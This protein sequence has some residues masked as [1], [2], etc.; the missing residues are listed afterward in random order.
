GI[1]DLRQDEPL[2]LGAQDPLEFEFSYHLTLANAE[3]NTAIIPNPDAYPIVGATQDIFVRLQDLSGNCFEVTMFT[4]TFAEVTS[5]PVTPN[6]YF[7][8]DQDENGE[9]IV[10]LQSLFTTMIL[11][12]QNPLDF[13]VTYHLNQADS[14]NG[15]NALPNPYTV[16]TSPLTIFVRV[17]NEDQPSCFDTTQN[18]EIVF[19]TPPPFNPTPSP[20]I[21]C[22]DDND[23]F[24]AFDLTLAD[25]D[26]TL[27]DPT[28]TV[29]YHTTFAN[30]QNDLFPIIGLYTNDN[31]Y[32]DEVWARVNSTQSS[33]FSVVRLE[34]FVR[35]I[36]EVFTPEPL[37]LCD[38]NNPG[39]GFEVFN[40]TLVEGEVLG[41]LDPTHYDIYYFVDES[42]AIAAGDSALDAPPGDYSQAI[43][44][45]GA[46]QNQ[47]AFNQT[48]YI[49]V[50]GNDLSV[51]PTTNPASNGE[52]CYAIIEL[53]LIVDPLP[54]VFQPANYEL[55][56]DEINGSTPTDQLSTFDLTTREDEITGGDASLTVVWFETA[57]DEAANIN[58]IPD[59]TAYQNR[60][61]APATQ[62]TPQTIFAR[63][64]DARDCKRIVTLTLVVLPNPIAN[65]PDP[66]EECDNG[67]DLD[68]GLASFDLT[69]RSAQI[70]GGQ[71]NVTVLYYVTEQEALAGVAGTEIPDPT[72][73]TNVVPFFDSVWARAIRAANPPSVNLACSDVVELFLIVL[74][75]PDT[76]TASFG[77]LFSCDG[78]GNGNAIFD[79]T[80]NN[81]HVIG[82]QDPSDFIGP[83]YYTTLGA[84]QAGIPGTEIPNS[85]FFP[86][87][88][89]P[90]TIWVRLENISTG[91]VRISS[92][93]LITGTFPTIF[94]PLDKEECDDLESGSDTDGINIFN[95]TDYNAEITG[96][97]ATYEVFYY[98]TAQD[99]IDGNAIQTPEA[100]ANT[101]SPGE[102]T[103]FVS[104][105]NGEGCEARTTLTLR[106]LAL[107]APLTDAQYIVCD[108]NNDGTGEFIFSTMDVVIANG[109]TDVVIT[110]HETQADALEGVSALNP[111]LVYE[112][113]TNPQIIWVRVTREVLPP[114]TS[115]VCF[116]VVEL[117]LLVETS[118]VLPLDIPP[119]V[120]CAE[121]TTAVFNF[122]EE[123]FL[124]FLYG[125]QAPP[126]YLLSFHTT[127]ADA[128]AGEEAIP[129]PESY[130]N[131][132]NPQTIYVRLTNTENGC[133][134]V[135]DF[136][137]EVSQGP[138]VTAPTSLDA[139]HDPTLALGF[140]RFVLS[141]KDDEITGGVAGV[142]VRYYETQ[143]DAQND[144]NAVS[145]LDYINSEAFL[146]TL[147]V[148]VIDGNTGC[149]S[150][151]TLLLRV[152]PNPVVTIPDPL[153]LCDDN[154]PG[155]GIEEFNLRDAEAQMGLSAS[156]EVFYYVLESDAIEGDT[157][158]AIPEVAGE[159]PYINETPFFQTVYARVVNT[160]QVLRCFTIVPIDLIVHP[161][162][163]ASAEIEDLVECE[164]NNDGFA[165]FNL[166]LRI[167]QILNGQDPDIHQVTF[168]RTA[169]EAQARLNQIVNTS[170]FPNTTNPQEIYTGILN[171]ETGCYS[172][173][174]QFFLIRV[175]EDATATAPAAPLV[176]CED[177]Q[178]S[179]VGTFDLS[180][181][182]A[183]ILNGQDP[184]IYVLTYHESL[185]QAEAGE[186]PIPSTTTA[187]E[188][189]TATI[190]ARVTFP[191]DDPDQPFPA[192]CY[193]VVE[194]QLEVNPLPVPV[195]FQ[196]S[197]RLCVDEFGNVIGQEFGAD[198]PPLIDTGLSRP[199]YE[200]IWEID[201]QEQ[202]G[203]IEGS[204]V[205]LAG[206]VYTVTIIDV[207]TGCE[208]S[209][210]TTVTLSSPPLTFSAI[211]T[212]G[213]FAQTHQIEAIATGLGSYV[214]S[215]DGGPFQQSGI[216]VNVS[217]GSHIVTITDENGCGSVEVEV[218]IIDYPLF[219]TPN[220]DGYNDRWNII[221]IASNPTA[222]IYIFDR[223]GKLL[224]QISPT[225]EGWDGT[226][227]GNP[228]PSS[229]YWFRVEYIED[230]IQKQFR[231][232]FTL[233]R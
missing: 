164:V 60:T 160:N 140:S 181:L 212:N 114:S 96:G 169:A 94:D 103:L 64:T 17:E 161:L 221:G 71:T 171:T 38:Y 128:V 53:E 155:D 73:Y 226:Y 120:K 147:F 52:S 191:V 142:E 88:S 178:G 134:A 233:K 180:S 5:G 207:V 182:N 72:D 196:D 159:V 177:E 93:L 40:L 2:T 43:I 32:V 220:N 117:L 162:P 192:G 85:G 23:G 211:A 16:N 137:I 82:V 133:F 4:I 151:T 219:F 25:E 200:F 123:E 20:L 163:D 194:V 198:S 54:V 218:G 132:S 19:D 203:E 81:P 87:T 9:E 176:V 165:E 44:G 77:D 217:V 49:L 91:C 101:S 76:P 21:E 148:R 97:N 95:L 208:F 229:D 184:T 14:D 102:Q 18:F 89:N 119:M 188:S 135:R 206:G 146:Q 24:F 1:F 36:P 118:P 186:N 34:L 131:Q 143:Q 86:S 100:Y 230:E 31:P 125:T 22:D 8:C 80:Q 213:A 66:L 150:F 62:P 193:N 57:A 42:D 10:N 139:C 129:N 222:K 3:A 199:E 215:L 185:A 183:E 84:A 41:S 113:F 167:G 205:A 202:V 153:E 55:C 122:L 51:D 83:T 78:D 79:L 136:E 157:S 130:T 7:I 121:G 12:G 225:S 69:Q 172:G 232:H 29:S 110:Y 98:E 105:F 173:G 209:A 154:D 50:V 37:R 92:F 174:E 197:Y 227:N 111:D 179:G 26:I 115:P 56:D 99:Q 65:T 152:L 214:Y 106:V 175:R 61:I 108:D 109:E 190:W 168:Y 189:P 138:S 204:I 33:C 127:L 6:P 228:L 210:S 46:Y 223:H 166:N 30:A 27:G 195:A 156:W 59:P 224:K 35:N 67:A 28:L 124:E 47:I 141:S 63:V 104:V 48:I 70:I 11:N 68:D 158:L 112:N 90:Q 145:A 201:G 126:L 107:P 75:L 39:D 45:P 149:F 231:G 187:Y 170:N 13:N 116:V 58:A 15:V 74:P 216:F 144:T